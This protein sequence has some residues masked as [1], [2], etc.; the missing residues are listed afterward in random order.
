MQEVAE[1]EAKLDL[2]FV[3]FDGETE[4]LAN[5]IDT[6]KKGVN[7]CNVA[8]S[9]AKDETL[10]ATSTGASKGKAML[11]VVYFLPSTIRIDY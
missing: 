3:G 5:D 10:L 1:G 4:I 8:F 7:I 2:G 6:T 11:R 9:P